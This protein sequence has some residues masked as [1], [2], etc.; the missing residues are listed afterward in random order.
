[1]TLILLLPFLFLAPLRAQQL[2]ALDWL[3]GYW[4]STVN[5]T[6]MEEFWSSPNGG[7]IL[8]MHRDVFPNNRS[9][10]EYLRIQE[11][12][13]KITYLASPFGANPTPFYLASLEDQH[14][15]FEN[16]EHDSPQRIIY[17]RKGETLEVRI[18]QADGSR[19][20]SWVWTLKS[21]TNNY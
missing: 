9:F 17:H 1:M 13:G 12:E 7:I 10:F 2:S 4:T 14:A 11:T 6:T 15:V 16:L 8:G 21:I 18:E 5:G 19:S 20:K 3:A